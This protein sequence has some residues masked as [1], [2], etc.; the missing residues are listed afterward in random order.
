[1]PS[2]KNFYISKSNSKEFTSKE[3]KE[4]T[5]AIKVRNKNKRLEEVLLEKNE[6]P[7]TDEYFEIKK[8]QLQ[9]VAKYE[10]KSGRVKMVVL[11]ENKTESNKFLKN[12][13]FIHNIGLT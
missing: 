1:M 7:K 10:S 4:I 8:R 3:I 5:E 11:G 12:Y 13:L 9:N 6:L 2:L